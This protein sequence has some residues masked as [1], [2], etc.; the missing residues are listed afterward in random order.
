MRFI[1]NDG[2]RSEYFKASE[3]GDCV[4]RSIAIATGKDYKEVYNAINELAKAERTGRKKRKTSNSREGVYRRTYEKYLNSLGWAFKP[5]MTIGS[6]CKVHLSSEDLAREGL[7]DG[8][9]I[10]R[11]SKHLTVIKDGVIN[12][13]YNPE[14]DGGRCVYGY[15][16]SKAQSKP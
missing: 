14:R 11:L 7:T 13:T 12:D 8:T 6:G 10:L 15:F 9:Y 5:L 2:G 4:T 16:Y 1:Y 3:V